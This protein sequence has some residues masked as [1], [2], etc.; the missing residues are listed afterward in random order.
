MSKECVANLFFSLTVYKG[1]T[2]AATPFLHAGLGGQHLALLG[3]YRSHLSLPLARQ[4]VF[5]GKLHVAQELGLSP[6]H[7]WVLL[8]LGLPDGLR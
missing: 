5:T 3:P 1:E 2:A 6:T 4:I 7:R 8:L